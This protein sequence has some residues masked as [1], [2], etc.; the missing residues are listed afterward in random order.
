MPEDST[1][2]PELRTQLAR[3]FARAWSDESIRRDYARDP[4][5]TLAD[6]GVDWPGELPLPDLPDL[7]AGSDQAI[8]LESLESSAGGALGTIGTVSCPTGCFSGQTT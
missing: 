8:D 3:F 2:S 7:P 4:R 6:A 5:A 1:L